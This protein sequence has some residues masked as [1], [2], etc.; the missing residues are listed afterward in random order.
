MPSAVAARTLSSAMTTFTDSAVPASGH[1]VDLARALTLGTHTVWPPVVLAP[2]AGVTNGPFRTLCRRAAHS[3]VA[4]DEQH[5][6]ATRMLFVNEMV[7]ANALL[8]RNYKTERMIRFQPDEQPRSLQLYGSDPVVIGEAIRRLASEGRVDH[9]DINFGCPARK[10]TRRGGGAAV[11][12]KRGLMRNI[13]RAAV[14]AGAPHG[15]PVTLKFRMGVRDDLL[16]FADT[17]RIAADEGAAAIAL[18]ARTAEQ[19]YA[20]QARW[21]AIGELKA[22][23]GD[24]IPVLGNGDIWEASDAL[25]MMAQ[26]GCDG[27][28][29]GRG[30]L[31]RPW[32]FS[33]LAAVFA[34]KECPPPP[35]LG[36]V[37]TVMREHAVA[38]DA[39][40]DPGRG[41]VE[42]RKHASWYV[43]GYPVGGEMRRRLAM[44]ATLDELD[45]LLARLDPS[46]EAVDGANRVTR[47]H[48][49]GPINVALPDG[50]L[51]HLD[52]DAPPVGDSD[53]AALSGG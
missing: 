19:H 14:Q 2:M 1:P 41:V 12:L 6:D 5:A 28:V 45:D 17:G 46:A 40:A 32:L 34:G 29:V 31:G 37:I 8:H 22:V 36:E 47:G 23:V 30:C 21:E 27:V 48:A 39:W 20:G 11:P 38:L 7:M 35:R 16:T 25:A 13:V 50:Y 4:P 42:F 52:D 44:V 53:A 3:V 10:V 24:A 18:H 51:D 26:T 15:V 49:N 43:T 33:D 9:I